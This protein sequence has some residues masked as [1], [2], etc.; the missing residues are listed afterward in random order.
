VGSA[1]IGACV[2]C[3]DVTHGQSEINRQQ[4]SQKTDILIKF[5]SEYG[6]WFVK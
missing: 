2:S 1:S 6:G 5:S 4:C 3:V